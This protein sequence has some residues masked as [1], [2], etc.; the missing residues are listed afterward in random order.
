[1][2]LFFLIFLFSCTTIH[3][4]QPVGKTV[5]VPPEKVEEIEQYD[6]RYS[7][8]F[9]ATIRKAKELIAEG[10]NLE[11]ESLLN[12]LEQ[13][14][15]SEIEAAEKANVLGVSAYSSRDYS[16]A[17]QLFLSSLSSVNENSKLRNQVLLNLAAVDY[18]KNDINNSAKSLVQIDESRLP[19]FDA[20]KKHLL[21]FLIANKLKRNDEEIHALINYFRFD[22]N[23]SDVLSNKYFTYL[24]ESFFKLSDEDKRS[25]ITQYKNQNKNIALREL[26][27]TLNNQF[28]QKGDRYSVDQLGQIVGSEYLQFQSEINYH[29]PIERSKIGVVL[30][31][32]GDK[33]NFANKVL[34]GITVAIQSMPESFELIVRDSQNVPAIAVNKVNELI[35]AENVSIIIGGLF[36]NTSE[37]EYEAARKSGAIFLSLSQVNTSRFNKNKL[38]FEIQGSVE[39]QVRTSLSQEA[40]SKFGTK[41]ALLYPNNELGHSYLDEFWNQSGDKGFDLIE[42]SGYEKGINDF[43]PAIGKLSGI[44]YTRAKEIE[45]RELVKEYQKESKDISEIEILKPTL[46]Y[47]WV[48]IPSYPKEALQILPSFKYLGVKKAHFV[49]GPSWMSRSLIAQKRF[50]SNINFVTDLDE[51]KKQIFV[52]Q[53]KTTSGIAPKLLETLGFDSMHLAK[54]ILQVSFDTRSDLAESLESKNIESSFLGDWYSEDNI[55]YKKMRLNVL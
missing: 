1:M 14:K 47:D 48:F 19:K 36:S 50:L 49:G 45:Y 46:E 5:E 12:S 15:L 38:L 7:K 30:P 52:E 44:E 3:Q 17:K 28:K 54:N 25:Y 8:K 41:V 55:W 34:N 10:K 39:S 31:L 6:A 16:K 37:R 23:R 43:R 20:K 22:S 51:S 9:V 4:N 29:Q 18:K 32:T 27:L 21:S 40:A 2:K 13:K 42:T 35:Q 26:V 24:K 53:Y 11:A 33:A